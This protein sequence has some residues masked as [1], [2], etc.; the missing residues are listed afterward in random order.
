MEATPARTTQTDH[1]L[2]ASPPRNP[3]AALEANPVPL[4]KG[5]LTQRYMRVEVA[6][7]REI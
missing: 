6:L 7:E 5:S 2:P 1:N 3:A 4:S